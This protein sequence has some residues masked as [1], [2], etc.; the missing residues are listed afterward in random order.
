M[1]AQSRW[2]YIQKQKYVIIS[3]CFIFLSVCCRI[4]SNFFI[5]QIIHDIEFHKVFLSEFNLEVY[6][7]SNHSE[8]LLH[9]CY[10]CPRKFPSRYSLEHHK[11]SKRHQN[12][13]RDTQLNNG[14]N[15]I[16][17]ATYPAWYKRINEC[18]DTII[19]MWLKTYV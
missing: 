1:V 6:M 3:S 13:L 14:L 2:H 12:K 5:E 10:I 4:F 11:K 18:H 19:F 7:R 16:D 9:V 17:S 8:K 15:T